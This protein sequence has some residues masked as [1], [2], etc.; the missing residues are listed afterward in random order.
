[1]PNFLGL[2]YPIQ[3]NS[4]GY[5]AKIADTSTIKSDLLILLLT[6]FGER[7][8]LPSFGTGLSSALFQQNNAALEAQVVSLIKS[9]I[10]KWEPRVSITQI[11][12][13]SSETANAQNPNNLSESDQHLMTITIQF[14]QFDNLTAVDTLVLQLPVG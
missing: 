10:S 7:V 13:V 2:K 3:K 9:A 12:A 4:Q 6:N 5:F 11:T 1:M 8:M 14:A